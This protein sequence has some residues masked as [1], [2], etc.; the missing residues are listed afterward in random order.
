MSKQQKAII[1]SLFG[2]LELLNLFGEDCKKKAELRPDGI[3]LHA[4]D[5]VCVQLGN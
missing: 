2:V 3:L 4:S 5:G 1:F